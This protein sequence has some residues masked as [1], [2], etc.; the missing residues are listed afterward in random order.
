MSKPKII[1]IEPWIDESELVQ[2]KRVIE[3][4]YLTEHK[5]TQ[6]FEEGIKSLTGAKYAIAT[7]NGTT[8]LYCGLKALGIGFGDEVL[9]P[10]LTF[11]ASSNAIIMT[12]ATP[13]FCD[14]EKDNLGID[15]REAE[16]LITERTKAIMPVH[17][18]GQSADMEKI[19]EFATRHHLKVIEDA[20]Q[21]IG[22]QFKGEHIGLRGDVSAI[23]FYGNK[24]I[25][26]GEGGIILTNSDIIAQ[27]CRRL[28]NHGRDHRGTFVH[29]HI[30]FNF[31]ITEMQSAIGVAQ[32]QKLPAI[33]Q[34]K[35]EIYDRYVAGLKD[36]P[37]LQIMP[38]DSRCEPVHW[39]TSCY[40]NQ[41]AELADYLAE[42]GIQTRRF[43]CP[44]HLQ[45][46]YQNQEWMNPERNYPISA[47][48][49]ER[50]ISL[51][52]SYGLKPEEQN[53]VI[54]KIRE[55]YSGS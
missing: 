13:I 39:F 43:F 6:E 34:R 44:L 48:A 51:P 45:P 16:A 28:K 52:S 17:L 1:Q 25:T 18:Y 42:N 24:T 20:A 55:F 11:V 40:T 30:G 29:E 46:C 7:S 36:I 41:R 37:E 31:S 2:L 14:I 22:V 49:Y 47:Q 9:V 54:E 27:S 35:Q 12:G 8:A 3:S 15:I 38:I 5:I 53:Y 19:I 4:T 33:I 21:S 26:C 10:D 32:L 23:S 50:G